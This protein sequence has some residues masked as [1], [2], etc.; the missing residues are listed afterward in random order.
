VFL[1]LYYREILAI[2]FKSG[3]YLKMVLTG[4]TM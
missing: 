2:R 1:Y 3:F 4:L